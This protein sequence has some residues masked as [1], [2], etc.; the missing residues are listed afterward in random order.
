MATR[1]RKLEDLPRRNSTQVKNRWSDLVHEVRASGSVAVTSHDRI[2]MVVVDAGKYRE[3][4]A[5]VE[6]AE[7]G[8]KNALAELT[9]EFDRHLASLH[10]GDTPRR[11]TSA[12]AAR[13]RTKA[14]PKAGPSF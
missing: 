13:G 8:K 6:E 12:M 1:I 7:R 9:A 4:E 5:L 3:M 10:D 11:M 14:R 2:E